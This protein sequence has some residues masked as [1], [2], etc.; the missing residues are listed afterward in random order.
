MDPIGLIEEGK[1]KRYLKAKRKLNH[2]H[3]VSHITQRAA[4]REPL[5]IEPDDFLF[6]LALLKELTAKYT[7]RIFAFCLMPNHVHLLLSPNEQNLYDAMRDLFS[8]YAMRFNHKYERKGHLFG[9]PYR[10]AVC[11]DDSYLLAASLYIHLNPVKAGI[12]GNVSDYRWSSCR[13][14][15]EKN[16]PASFVDP[17]FI[18]AL[19]CQN[20]SEAR[21]QYR[22]L[23]KNGGGI[24]AGHVLEQEDAIEMFQRKLASIF[25]RLFKQIDKE[26]RIA[27]YAGMDLLA[28]DVLEEQINKF[29]KG[30]SLNRPESRQAKKFLI[31]QLVAR[32]F[33]RSEIAEQLGISRKTVYNLLKS[34][35]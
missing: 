4:G 16:A 3:L 13:L 19:L 32:G 30:D 2:P 8:R 1:I 23:L 29:K 10:Q 34:R 14:Y 22:V 33:K 26:N 24:K 18:L 7:L 27:G 11:M 35:T 5:F 21:Q 31:Q 6:M 9:G 25:P 17:V 12:A 20:I 15:C 28:L